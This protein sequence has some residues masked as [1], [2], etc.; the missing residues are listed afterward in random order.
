M[1]PDGGSTFSHAKD[2][3]NTKRLGIT[4]AISHNLSMWAYDLVLTRCKIAIFTGV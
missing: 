4:V 2:Y 1:L 3:N